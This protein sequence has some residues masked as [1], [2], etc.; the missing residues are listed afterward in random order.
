MTSRRAHVLA[1][2]RDLPFDGGYCVHGYDVAEVFPVASPEMIVLAVAMGVPCPLPETLDEAIRTAVPSWLSWYQVPADG[3]LIFHAGLCPPDVQAQRARAAEARRR[4]NW[5]HRLIRHYVAREILR[6]DWHTPRFLVS[7]PFDVPVLDRRGEL[8]ATVTAHGDEPA[9]A[10]G[11]RL[12]RRVEAR[13]R[14]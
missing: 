11:M 6:T 5:R 4:A 8:L 9:V 12:A 2:L 7:M 3:S 10:A 1:V 13:R 14:R